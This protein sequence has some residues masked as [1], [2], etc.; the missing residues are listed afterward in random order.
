FLT[1][2]VAGDIAP[3][4]VELVT[5][6]QD[7]LLPWRPTCPAER[8][9]LLMLT[10]PRLQALLLIGLWQVRSLNPFRFLLPRVLAC[11]RLLL[12]PGTSVTPEDVSYQD[13]VHGNRAYCRQ[14]MRSADTP[15]GGVQ[16]LDADAMCRKRVS[17]KVYGQGWRWWPE[18]A[19][20]P[21][22]SWE[23]QRLFY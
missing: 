13:N 21:A 17:W 4:R 9:G 6:D 1:E 7:R 12:S 14:G 23:M 20:S 3:K 2:G 18:Q 15:A 22:L 19:R 5:L 8:V 10:H 16:I 11:H